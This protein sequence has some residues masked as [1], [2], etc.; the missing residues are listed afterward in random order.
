MHSPAAVPVTI[1]TTEPRSRTEIQCW[2]PGQAQPAAIGLEQSMREMAQDP[3]EI[4]S[5]YGLPASARIVFRRCQ[6][7]V[8]AC[9]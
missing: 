1:A 7:A 5:Y 2:M 9:R 3:R 8:C 4:R 6:G